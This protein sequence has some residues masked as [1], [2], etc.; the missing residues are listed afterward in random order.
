MANLNNR[1]TAAEAKAKAENVDLLLERLYAQIKDA[2]EYNC[3]TTWFNFGD[4]EKK[5]VV[6]AIKDLRFN[7][8]EVELFENKEIADVVHPK[9]AEVIDALLGDN[10]GDSNEE[11]KKEIIWR[12]ILISWR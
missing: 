10:T 4:L 12:D 2:A 8:Y 3:Y 11:G 6:E 1:I 9:G 5:L 7:G